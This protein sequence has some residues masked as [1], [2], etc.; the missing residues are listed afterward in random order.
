MLHSL[1]SLKLAQRLDRFCAESGRSLTVLL[2]F[3]VSG[4]ESKSGFPA[5]DEDCWTD[6]L[7]EIERILALPHLW[8]RGLMTM[9]P[10]FEDPEQSRPYFQKL[11]R[12]Q[13]FLAQR[14]PQTDW[15]ELSMGTSADFPVAVQEGATYVRVGQAI[16]GLRT[17][18]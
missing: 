14:L 16:L 6:L 18:Q 4:E 2:E 17:A 13:A 3:N 15:S 10:Y 8:P 12:L 11:R 1:D 9:P 7:P 5:W